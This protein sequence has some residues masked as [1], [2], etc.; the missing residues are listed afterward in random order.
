MSVRSFVRSSVRIFV[1]STEWYMHCG[2]VRVSLDKNQKKCPR[3]LK[4]PSKT[5]ISEE[6]LH[7][8]GPCF[9]ALFG[10]FFGDFC[11]K[12]PQYILRISP[13][14]DHFDQI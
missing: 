11:K 3:F 4:K 13:E 8:A 14:N 7:L 2:H 12:V 9:G 10:A 6:W 1:N 5:S